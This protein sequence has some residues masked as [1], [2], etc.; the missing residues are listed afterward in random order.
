MYDLFESLTRVKNLF[1]K[2]MGWKFIKKPILQFF[3]NLTV[4]VVSGV[5]PKKIVVSDVYFCE[6][7]IMSMRLNSILTLTWSFR[8]SNFIWHFT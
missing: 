2:Q 4:Q 7:V 1:F 8:E 5:W 6:Q 3:L